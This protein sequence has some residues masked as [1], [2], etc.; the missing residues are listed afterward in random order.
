VSDVIDAVTAAELRQMGYD[1][2]ER[3]PDHAWVPKS[4]VKQEILGAERLPGGKQAQINVRLH[5]SEPFRW[6]QEVES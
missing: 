3:V 4:A 5:V 2:P 1:V 6:G